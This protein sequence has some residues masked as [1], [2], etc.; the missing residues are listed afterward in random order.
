MP[1]HNQMT[2]RVCRLPLG[3]NGH[4]KSLTRERKKMG[5]G[6]IRSRERGEEQRAF[7]QKAKKS[8]P[9]QAVRPCCRWL[10]GCCSLR[11]L[12]SGRSP[13]TGKAEKHQ[14]DAGPRGRGPSPT[15]RLLDDPID[16][17]RPLEK[18]PSHFR[19]WRAVQARSDSHLF[20][21]GLACFFPLWP[22]V[23]MAPTPNTALRALQQFAVLDFS[24]NTE[25]IPPTPNA[26]PSAAH[27]LAPTP[28]LIL[29]P[30]AHFPGYTTHTKE[31][32][33]AEGQKGTEDVAPRGVYGY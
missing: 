19:S 24:Q 26:L 3:E 5:V 6:R 9:R 14:R 30:S 22:G 8:A 31:G 32:G 7:A 28:S 27:K 21:G 15:L 12:F 33:W 18:Q 16:W 2:A 20:V 13:P 25:T 17:E 29:N 23:A 4:P 11:S 1:S 10:V